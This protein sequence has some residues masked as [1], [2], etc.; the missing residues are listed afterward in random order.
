MRRTDRY[1]RTGY[2]HVRRL[3]HALLSALVPGTGQIAGG[4][5]RRGLVL[6]TVVVALVL[7]L[8]IITMVGWDLVLAWAIQ[9]TVLLALLGA[10]VVF[11]AFRLYAVLDAYFTG[12]PRDGE[13]QPGPPAFVAPP[14]SQLV[15][16][17]GGSPPGPPARR[18][19][20]VAGV[21]AAAALVVL[22][23]L[24]L[25]PH[26]VAGYYAYLSRDFLI[27]VF[28]D[29]EVP[30]P[31]T[32]S[33][34]IVTT[35]TTPAPVS[36]STTER[37]VTTR[38]TTT[39]TEAPTTTTEPPLEW[40]AD[41]RLTLLLIGTDAGFGRKG[42]RADSIMV[43]TIDL[44]KGSVALFGIPR[45][46][47]S[48]P[49]SEAAA[50]A[51][52]TD[53]YPEMISNLYEAA[54]H[55]PELAPEGGDPGA[56][57]LRDTASML[58]GIPIHHYAVVDMG[59]FVD[60]VDAFGGIKI[61]VKERVWVRLSPPTADEDY[62]VY[63]IKPGIQELDG[64]EA[65][66]FARS[67]TGNSDYDRMRRQRC[68]IMALLYQNGVKDLAFNFPE[69]I[70]VFQDHMIT[71]IPID[72]LSDLIRV[73]GKVQTDKMV[74]VGFGPPD[75]ITG[76]NELNYNILD[77][78]LVQATVQ[79]YINDPETVLERQKAV[80]EETGGSDCWKVD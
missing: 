17:P 12:R 64:H 66:A 6:L 61:N 36:T 38:R 19:R 68:V 33:L 70:K 47:G 79:E 27:T 59:G 14:H 13:V 43:A 44:E 67:R 75:Y 80:A 52:G 34:P 16:P 11:L 72:R 60:L 29:E 54:Q 56:V 25:A 71:D 3:L 51:L 20:Q 4:A 30:A 22:V 69:V 46:T 8:V 49:L 10:N 7:L 26:V 57:V 5:L 50:Q 18:H 65:L 73:R 55:H 31:T 63:D 58:L 32:T 9:P 21:L 74:S 2:G 45:N 62:R 39:T 78:E 76:R 35:T 24:T 15:A 41:Q 40:G 1:A 77:T 48:L 28:V 53:V 37:T 23:L 42:A